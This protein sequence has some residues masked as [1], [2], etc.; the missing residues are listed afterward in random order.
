MPVNPPDRIEE[1]LEVTK[2]AFASGSLIRCRRRG[3]P[4]GLVR[5]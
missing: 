1:L 2:D 5:P 3:E 4:A